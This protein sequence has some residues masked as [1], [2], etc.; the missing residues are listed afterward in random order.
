MKARVRPALGRR[1]PHA[2]LAAVLAITAIAAAELPSKPS[3][4]PSVEPRSSSI[5]DT[6]G[7]NYHGPAPVASYQMKVGGA[8]IDIGFAPGKLILPREAFIRWVSLSAVAVSH[9][10]GQFPVRHAR[11]LIIPSSDRS[12]VGS[13]SSYG[14]RGAATKVFV[15]NNT[16][17][18]D[19]NRDW[20]L[21]H[22]FVHYAFPS[23]PRKNH[24]MEEGL[25]T[26]VEPIARLQAGELSAD[27][28]W[29]DLMRGLPRGMPAAGDR[30]LDQTPSWGRTYW[31]GAMFFLLADV[32]IRAD[33][34]NAKGLQTALTAIVAK[35]GNIQVKWP[36][37]RA[38]KFGDDAIG[39]P[40]LRR[41]YRQMRGR[42]VKPDL[43]GLWRALGI[44]LDGDHVVY[45]DKAP[46]A[47]IRRG[48]TPSMRTASASG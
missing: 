7:M 35:G 34:H 20:V 16:S 30:G 2:S 26:Y 4:P 22:E 15:G 10:Y 42:P 14:E 43:P 48:I 46:L 39:A 47:Y 1:R 6:R 12:G 41:L 21:T 11:L 36:V 9:F 3:L 44:R 23:V 29:G 32:R 8:Q 24:W 18:A 38:L 45:D 28:V 19:L 37:E 27:Q 17:E 40:V 25:A 5:F 13:G 31:G 33:T